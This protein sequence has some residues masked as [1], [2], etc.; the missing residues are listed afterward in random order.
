MATPKAKARPMA[1]LISPKFIYRTINDPKTYQCGDYHIYGGFNIAKRNFEWVGKPEADTSY[2]VAFLKEPDVVIERLTRAFAEHHPATAILPATFDMG[3]VGV[4]SMH[5]KLQDPDITFGVDP[6]KEALLLDEDKI[7]VKVQ[8][9]MKMAWTAIK[10]FQ[11]MIGFLDGYTRGVI[12]EDMRLLDITELLYD[13]IPGKNGKSD[14][15][16]IKQSIMKSNEITVSKVPIQDH[17]PMTI[18]YQL[19]LDLVA[20]PT[21]NSLGATMRSVKVFTRRITAGENALCVRVGSIVET[22]EGVSLTW[23]FPSNLRTFKAKKEK[24]K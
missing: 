24:S 15:Y 18:K 12:P 7:L 2:C 23:A 14:G 16:R 13:V 1:K 6:R 10:H 21:L 5:A 3:I 9:P 11:Q 17:A 22:S 20:K 4:A 19:G 8:N